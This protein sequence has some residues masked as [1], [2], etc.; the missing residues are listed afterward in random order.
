MT[1]IRAAPG[2][3]GLLPAAACAAG[4]DHLETGTTVKE[5]TLAGLVYAPSGFSGAGSILEEQAWAGTLQSTVLYN[6]RTKRGLL[7]EL[8][9]R[10]LTVSWQARA[11]FSPGIT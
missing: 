10:D 2:T 3:L 9:R 1:E 6:H 11:L 7:C 5:F 4:P 8:R